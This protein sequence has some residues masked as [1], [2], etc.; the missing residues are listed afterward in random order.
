MTARERTTHRR[1]VSE[2]QLSERAKKIGKIA[3]IL[4]YVTALAFVAAGIY[5][6]TLPGGWVI[7]II[8]FIPAVII[9]IETKR[10]IKT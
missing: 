10:V 3:K 7:G 9:A 4:G 6:M 1:G 8:L 5:W 2:V